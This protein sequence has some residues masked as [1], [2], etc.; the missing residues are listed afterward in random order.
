MWWAFF[1]QFIDETIKWLVAHTTKLN[2]IWFVTAFGKLNCKENNPQISLCSFTE[3]Y[4]VP[5]YTCQLYIST[6]KE[7]RALT[8]GLVTQDGMQ[9]AFLWA[10]LQLS[11]VVFVSSQVCLVL[12]LFLQGGD[13]IKP[14]MS[15]WGRD[16]FHNCWA[17]GNV[18]CWEGIL[19][20]MCIRANSLFL[21]QHLGLSNVPKCIK[22]HSWPYFVGGF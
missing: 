17:L 10:E 11:D 22:V 13:I 8:H 2:D 5:K 6:R 16:G 9:T 12:A 7:E 19:R 18:L 3:N 14:F 21:K 1:L 15:A 4:F 20:L